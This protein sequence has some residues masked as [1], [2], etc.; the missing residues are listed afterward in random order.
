MCCYLLD[1]EAQY[2]A[3][4]SIHSAGWSEYLPCCEKHVPSSA[5]LCSHEMCWA[6]CQLLCVYPE[7]WL[8]GLASASHRRN[9]R[10]CQWSPGLACIQK[11]LFLCHFQWLLFS[12]QLFAMESFLGRKQRGLAYFPSENDYSRLLW[13]VWRYHIHSPLWGVAW[14][15]ELWIGFVYWTVY[16]INGLKLLFFLVWWVSYIKL[17]LKNAMVPTLH[18]LCS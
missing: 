16:V 14:C 15:Q 9:N 5:P 18:W 17:T 10:T 8:R 13:R 11:L 2:P 6:P 4:I 7:N 1:A 3:G 12:K